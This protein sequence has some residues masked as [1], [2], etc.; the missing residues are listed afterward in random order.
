MFRSSNPVLT[1]NRF[2]VDSYDTLSTSGVGAVGGAGESSKVMT[3]QGTVNKSFI[4]LGLCIAGAALVWG[5]FTT[6]AISPMYGLISGLVA[7]I[8][9]LVIY[10]A[11]RTAVVAAPIYALLKGPA[12]AAM[13]FFVAQF[14][15]AKL[16]AKG[17]TAGGAGMGVVFQAV[18]ITFGI[19]A[20]ML[21]SYTLGLIRLGGFAMRCI[22]I[23][24]VGL[25]LTYLASI[26]LPMM[27]VRF[28]VISINNTSPLSIG[29]SLFAVVLGSL[30]LVADFQEIEVAAENQTP[31]HMEWYLAFGLLASL[32]WL[33]IEVLRLLAKLRGRD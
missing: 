11:P 27:G 12:L 8:V 14:V 1:S 28:D 6:N 21:L 9:A 32:I 19:F 22:T 24:M 33:Y 23:G 30:T 16:R 31:K 25:V 15:D 20:A 3:V 4:L 5:P 18:L 17:I 29:I 10:F 26:L 2:G 13:S 7:A